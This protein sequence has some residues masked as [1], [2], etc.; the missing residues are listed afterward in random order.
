M[1]GTG[2]ENLLPDIGLLPDCLENFLQTPGN[3]NG[4]RHSLVF[5]QISLGPWITF[6]DIP[7]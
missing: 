1:N 7:S 4:S 6:L 3:I 2:S 5:K